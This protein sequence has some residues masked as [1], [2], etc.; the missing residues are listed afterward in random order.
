MALTDNRWFVLVLKHVD[1]MLE[2]GR[3]R[4]CPLFG[5]VIDIGK[6]LA[7]RL[8]SLPHRRVFALQTSTGAAT[9]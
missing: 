7:H 1:S 9:T 5:G 2:F 3:G 8:P 6:R 4:E